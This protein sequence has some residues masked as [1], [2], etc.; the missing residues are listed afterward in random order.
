MTSSAGSERPLLSRRDFVRQAGLL[1]GTVT[2]GTEG[3]RRCPRNHRCRACR[4]W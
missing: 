2:L 3:V 4:R 1:A